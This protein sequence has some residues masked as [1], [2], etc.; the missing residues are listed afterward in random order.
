MAN[1]TVSIFIVFKENSRRR[2]VSAAY[3]GN[4]R[5]KP[6]I[7]KSK[8]RELPCPNGCYFIRWYEG[9]KQHWKSVG[10]D[11]TE[12][13]LGQQRQERVLAGESVPSQERTPADRPTLAEAVKSFLEERETQTDARGL[14]RWK[15]ELELFQEV[16]GKR[17][18]ADVDRA[19]I[20]RLIAHYQKKLKSQPRTVF[21]RIQSL[22]TFLANR[23]HEVDFK[24]R[25]VGNRK[26]GDIPKYVEPEVDYYSEDELTK[27]FAACDDEER[28]RYQFFLRTGCREREVMFATW[29][30]VYFAE[31]DDD[32][33]TDDQE[34]STYTVN[35]K[36]KM[37]FTIKNHK[38]REIPLSDDLVEALKTYQVLYP[39]RKTIF[40]NKDHG[41]EG[42]FLGKLK[43]IVKWA[44]LPGEW[45][46]H[47]FRRT[48]ATNALANGVPIHVVQEWLG[49][50]RERCPI[51]ESRSGF[52]RYRLANNESGP[53][54]SRGGNHSTDTG[55]SLGTHLR[56]PRGSL[57]NH[58][59]CQTISLICDR[60]RL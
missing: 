29:A 25:A 34:A 58:R 3:A 36:P 10:P 24:F 30:D 16:C 54:S 56:S 45:S 4:A 14:A 41:P 39:N 7:G 11:P 9:R 37:G 46:L 59:G 35:E 47:K 20:I 8:N 43:A 44:E 27:F 2:T 12:A 5:L 28:I 48:F 26:G 21:N 49:R 18:L 15:W 33:A 13:L 40:E 31:Q 53:K 23:K 6:L 42:H 38:S 1:T 17:N 19:D 22:G 55:D 60:R 52:R 50:R 57:R 32:K 51:R